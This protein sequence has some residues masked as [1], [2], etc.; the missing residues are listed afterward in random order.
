MKNCILKDLIY[1]YSEAKLSVN[2]CEVFG[3]EMGKVG[4]NPE[5]TPIQLRLIRNRLRKVGPPCIIRS[6][7]QSS[8]IAR[9]RPEPSGVVRSRSRSESESSGI[10]RNRPK[11]S[12]VVRSR[13]ESF[14]V[15]RSRSESFGVLRRRPESSGFIQNRLQTETSGVVWGRPKS[16]H[17]GSY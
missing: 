10:V 1:G 11:S 5:S 13:S 4:K 16:R 14:G 15:V 12:G 9:S 2:N 6:R 7:S 8:R 17:K 3:I